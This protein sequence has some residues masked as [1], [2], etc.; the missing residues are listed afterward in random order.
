MYFPLAWHFCS[1]SSQNKIEKIK[2]SSLKLITNN[3]HNDYK[4][5]LN[6]TGNSTI[7]IKRLR[8]LA[9][10][11]FKTFNNFNPNFMKDIFNFFPYSTHRKHDIFLHSRNTSNYGDR[12]LRTL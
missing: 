12:S 9:L 2:Y 6:D 3:Y 8:T 10:E 11:I 4:F 7:E 1:K 5:L